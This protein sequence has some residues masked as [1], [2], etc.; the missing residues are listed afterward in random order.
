MDRKIKFSKNKK[1]ILKKAFRKNF[2]INNNLKKYYQ[3]KF[4]NK[5]IKS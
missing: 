3:N 1:K 5:K 2:K 4:F